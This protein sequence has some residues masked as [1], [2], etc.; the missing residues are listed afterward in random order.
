MS[1]IVRRYH[2]ALSPPFSEDCEAI[3]A[4][5]NAGFFAIVKRSRTYG[6]ILTDRPV[7]TAE[8]AT[9]KWYK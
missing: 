3:E 1:P 7:A 2:S 6:T 8:A 5:K 4:W 9:Y